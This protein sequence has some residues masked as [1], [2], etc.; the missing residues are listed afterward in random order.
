MNLV[1]SNSQSTAPVK[2]PSQPDLH[3]LHRDRKDAPSEHRL[4][5]TDFILDVRLS[6]KE[7]HATPCQLVDDVEDQEGFQAA[8]SLK[9][10]NVT[11]QKVV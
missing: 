7:D 11:R 3:Q 4:D 1:Q 2:L 9:S 6:H 8:P 5:P 10:T